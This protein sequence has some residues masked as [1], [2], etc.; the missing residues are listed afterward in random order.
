MI[1]EFAEEFMWILNAELAVNIPAMGF[2][3]FYT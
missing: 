3:R 2:N 1:P